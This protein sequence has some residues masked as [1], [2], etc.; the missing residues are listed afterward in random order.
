[1]ALK[2]RQTEI[3]L[4][5]SVEQTTLSDTHCTA[6]LTTRGPTTYSGKPDIQTHIHADGT[7]HSNCGQ[8]WWSR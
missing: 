6:V 3:K 2:H 4:V 8:W 7:D 1:M 5:D